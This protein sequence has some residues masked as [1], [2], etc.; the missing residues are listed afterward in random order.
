MPYLVASILA[1][2]SALIILM[3][4]YEAD[5][6]AIMSQIDKM[7]TMIFMVDGFVNT[8]IESGGIILKTDSSGNWIS[9]ESLNFQTLEDSGILIEGSSLTPTDSSG[10]FATTMKLPNDKVVWHIIPNKDDSSSYKLLIDMS[11][12]SS[13]MRKAIFS[14]SFIGREYCQK[15]LFGKFE[16]LT[17]SFNNADDF[18]DVSGS[19]SDGK[20][21]CIVYK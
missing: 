19:K 10:G 13:L 8:Y 18:V 3:T 9:S 17:N 1:V 15:M 11:N 21:V 16:T 14:E 5:D 12:D 6:S 2:T 4:R 20:F 7:K